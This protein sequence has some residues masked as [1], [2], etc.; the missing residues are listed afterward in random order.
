ML[1]AIL[2]ISALALAFG[3]LLGFSSIRFHVEENPIAEK[4]NNLL[5]QTQC[6]QCSYL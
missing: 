3:L 1:S 2:A 5:P 4:I 6:G